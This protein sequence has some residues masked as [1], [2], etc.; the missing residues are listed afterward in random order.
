MAD[1][2]VSENRPVNT[3]QTT[4]D[5][6]HLNMVIVFDIAFAIFAEKRFLLYE[7]YNE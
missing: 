1:L 3:F 4:R 6:F 7:E 5:Q 2:K